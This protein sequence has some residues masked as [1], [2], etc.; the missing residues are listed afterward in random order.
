MMAMAGPHEKKVLLMGDFDPARPGAD[1]P[2]P[3]YGDHSDFVE[4]FEML[5]RSIDAFIKALQSQ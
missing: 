5:D 4:V 2:D 1:V 3:Y